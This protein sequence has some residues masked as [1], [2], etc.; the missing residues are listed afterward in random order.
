MKTLQQSMRLCL[1]LALLA[2]SF[3]FMAIDAAA[4]DKKDEKVVVRSRAKKGD[5]SGKTIVVEVKDGKVFVDG[6]IVADGGKAGKKIEFKS[7]DGDSK[8]MSLFFSGDE[9]SEHTE[10]LN[11]GHVRFDRSMSADGEGARI[12]RGIAPMINRMTSELG[13]ARIQSRMAPMMDRVFEFSHDGGAFSVLANG[14]HME[15]NG[16][17][18]KMEMKSRELAMKIRHEEGD[19]ATME[20]EL[21]QLL[22]DI[23]AAKQESNETHI[24]KM[25]AELEKLEQKMGERSANKSDIISRRKKELLGQAEKFDW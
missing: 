13:E 11:G 16:E 23:Y 19:T 25:R 17:V 2:S 3:A 14:L 21:D 22:S 8:T 12:R 7:E 4:Q 15:S 1:S 20:A 9:D 6:E 24:N 10:S 5:A 18:M